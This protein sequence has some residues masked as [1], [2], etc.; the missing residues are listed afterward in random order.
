MCAEECTS[1]PRVVF[2]HQE[3]FRCKGST[4]KVEVG[5][6]HNLHI[7]VCEEHRGDKEWVDPI[8]GIMTLSHSY[9]GH[10]H[11]HAYNLP[12]STCKMHANSSFRRQ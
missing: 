12:G 8:I 6:C 9:L 11:V 7:R 5:I 3:V 2:L 4:F 10:Q 1:R